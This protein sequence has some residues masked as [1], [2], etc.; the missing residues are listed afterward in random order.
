MGFLNVSKSSTADLSQAVCDPGSQFLFH[1]GTVFVPI[2][3]VPQLSE[4]AELCLALQARNTALQAHIEVL[5]LRKE[6]MPPSP[7]ERYPYKAEAS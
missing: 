3:Q 1:N 2:G 5:E 6:L 7:G 4:M